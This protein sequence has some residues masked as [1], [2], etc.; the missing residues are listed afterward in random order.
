MS[1]A[2]KFRKVLVANRAE[3]AVRVAR[4]LREMGI[5]SV[6]VYSEADRGALHTSVADEAIPIGP[7][8]PSES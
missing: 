3:I 6:A 7:P 5:P 1:P 4:T 2:R 8:A